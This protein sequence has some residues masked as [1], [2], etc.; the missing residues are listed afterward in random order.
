MLQI[1]IHFSNTGI[2]DERFL[3]QVEDLGDGQ[4]APDPHL[5]RRCDRYVNK[6]KN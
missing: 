4:P 5:L 1:L 2:Q 6:I 3:Q